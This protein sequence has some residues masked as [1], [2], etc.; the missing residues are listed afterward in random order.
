MKNSVYFLFLI[1]VLLSCKQK[2]EVSSYPKNEYASNFSLQIKNNQLQ[3]TSAGNTVSFPAQPKISRCIITT[4]SASAYLE[5]IGKANCIVGVSSPEYFYNSAI[6]K[7]IANHSIEN[8]GNEGSLNFEKIIA[9]K[10]ELLI[11]T[12]NPNYEKILTQL[13]RY[14]IK[15][16]YVEE[17]LELH[18][19]GKTEYL[20]L[21]GALFGEREKADSIYLCV[22]NKYLQL[23]KKVSYTKKRPTVFTNIMYGDAWY[24][25][26]GKSFVSTL[27]K[28]AGGD[29]IWGEN[30][31][32]GTITLNFEEVFSKAKNADFWIGASNFNSRHELI[33]SNAQYAWFNA[34]KK[35]QIYS[36]NK[37]ENKNRANDYYE[38]GSIYADKSLSDVIKILHSELLPNY[39][40]TYLKKLN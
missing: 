12:H 3:I 4:T 36:M 19:L 7:G 5:A 17:Y 30:K 27:F 20:K 10:P 39:E 32:T 33:N 2:N 11:T 15:I 9:L 18:P 35:G 13:A 28:D 22:K 34:Y 23:K 8:I 21:F 25:A 40:L 24:M 38:S 14:G 29:Y 31:D 1:L 26:G 16:I 6:A 37:R